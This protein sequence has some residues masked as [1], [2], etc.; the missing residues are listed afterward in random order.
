M[1]Q[2]LQPPTA[3]APLHTVADLLD[4]SRPKPAFRHAGRIV[5]AAWAL[6]LVAT[7][8]RLSE[9]AQAGFI[10]LALLVSVAGAVLLWTMARAHQAE[11]SE[12]DRL[13][14]AVALKHLA[15]AGPRVESIMSHP[16][17]SLD[18]RLRAMLLL[19]S[20]LGRQGRFED[21]LAVYD[22]LVDREGI[23]GPGG[24]M[25][26]IGRAMAMLHTDHLYDADRAINELRRLIDRGGIGMEMLA[27]DDSLPAP[28]ADAT[29][30]ASLR[31][32]E[33]YRDLKTG[34]LSEAV[35]LFNT[36]L[37]QFRQGLGHRVAETHALVAIA[38]DQLHHPDEARQHFADATA[39]QPMIELVGRYPELRPLVEKYPVTQAPR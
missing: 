5:V 23:A 8:L 7:L 1:T 37:P 26:K 36:H 10:G 17:R 19:A 12:L 3:P 27:I 32:V 14:D 16:M 24:A 11:K 6:V 4:L 28:P 9:S 31:L 22:E 21:A 2:T 35:E 38:F 25:V 34:H 18:H 13:E 33:L 39:L 29:A 30:I 15:T 20:V